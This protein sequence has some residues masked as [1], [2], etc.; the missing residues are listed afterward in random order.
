MVR[1]WSRCAAY[2]GQ[3]NYA[4][5]TCHRLHAGD[6][7]PIQR[8]IMPS[9]G[10][11]NAYLGQGNFSAAVAYCTQSIAVNPKSA[12]AFNG[13]CWAAAI[14]DQLQPALSDC[15]QSPA[16][17]TSQTMST[18]WTAAVLLLPEARAVR[19]NAIDDYNAALKINPSCAS[20]LYGRGMVELKKGDTSDANTDTPP[21]KRSSLVLLSSLPNTAS[22]LMASSHPNPCTV[23]RG[24]AYDAKRDYD[25]CRH[26]NR[27]KYAL[28]Y[29]MRCLT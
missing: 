16:G 27:S 3:G 23:N 1:S 28:A 20:S 19:C 6:R 18:H 29:N 2:N 26:R 14:I 10:R 11:C 7:T 22:R 5:A 15:N 25:H 21:P 24:N 17:F 13:R 12:A 9:L 4:A 8:M